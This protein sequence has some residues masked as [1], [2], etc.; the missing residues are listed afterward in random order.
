[1]FFKKQKR[2][3][4]IWMFSL[5]QICFVAGIVL[6]RLDI[7]SLAFITGLLMGFSVAVNIAFLIRWR[8]LRN[9]Q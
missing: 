3:L 8:K 5:A 1:M 7:P 6:S 4:P 9:I 2:E